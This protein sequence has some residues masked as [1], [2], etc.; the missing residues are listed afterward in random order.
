M[1]AASLLV[2]GVIMLH[3]ICPHTVRTIQNMILTMHWKVM[4]HPA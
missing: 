2:T 4:G 3:D 1:Q